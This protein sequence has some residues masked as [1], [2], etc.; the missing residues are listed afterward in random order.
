M[1]IARYLAKQILQLTVALT[2]VLLAVAVLIRLLN[3]LGEATEGNIDP[4]VLLLLMSYRLPEFV[5]LILPLALMLSVLLA[6]GRMYADN[7]M[8]VLIA[9]GLSKIRLLMYTLISASVVIVLIAYL[10]LSLTPKG[11]LNSESLLEQQKDLNEFDVMVPGIFQ[12]ISNGARTTYAENIEDN[13]IENVFMHETESDRLIVSNSASLSLGEVIQGDDQSQAQNQDR[14]VI[15]VEGSLSE[16]MATGEAYSV[17]NFGELAIRIPQREISI[18]LV[19]EEQ[20]MN[21]REL[22]AEKSNATTAE[23]QWRLSL[24]LIIPII[25][26]LAVPLSKVNPRQGRFAKLAPAVFIYIIYF[27][28]LLASRDWLADGVLPAVIGLWWV[29][30]LFIGLGVLMFQE[31]MPQLFDLISSKPQIKPEDKSNA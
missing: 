25:C 8:T 27:A 22:F 2:F 4:S 1:I 28:L 21:T 10:S 6:Y 12:D 30:I 11:L 20:A 31:K 17:T 26:L 5:Q 9:S 7:E 3:Y 14:L 16:G 24:I 19:I 23:L 18:D 13:V 15:F 29:H